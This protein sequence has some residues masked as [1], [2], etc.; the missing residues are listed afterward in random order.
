[1]E[2]TEKIKYNIICYC[3]YCGEAIIEDEVCVSY[4]SQNYHMSCFR[5]IYP[6]DMKINES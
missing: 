2:R 3:I 5:L 1:M 6:D 4:K